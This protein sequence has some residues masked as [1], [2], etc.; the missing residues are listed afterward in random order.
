MHF[1]RLWP[2]ICTKNSRTLCPVKIYL[3][4]AFFRGGVGVFRE[5][6]LNGGSQ[7]TKSAFLQKRSPMKNS[8]IKNTLFGREVL[9]YE[10]SSKNALLA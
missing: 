10:A 1:Y 3:F 8:K 4:G 9:Y 6:H 2:G 7:K 5:M